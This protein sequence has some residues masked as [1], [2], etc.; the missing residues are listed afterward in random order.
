MTLWL[1]NYRTRVYKISSCPMGP[2][3][4]YDLFE[5]NT[6]TEISS[7]FKPTIQGI[8]QFVESRSVNTRN[9]LRE[10][11]LLSWSKIEE[12]ENAETN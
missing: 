6:T 4:D 8:R 10:V 1:I 2:G 11:R 7:Q 3:E 9:I 5:D 12:E